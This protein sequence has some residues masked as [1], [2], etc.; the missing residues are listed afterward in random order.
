MKSIIVDTSVI[1]KWYNEEESSEKASIIL[2]AIESQEVELVF[3]QP[4]SLEIL[5]SLKISKGFSRDEIEVALDGFF[6]LRIEW[7]ELDRDLLMETME[8]LLNQNITSYDAL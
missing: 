8:V 1:L 6:Q 4:A 2:R 3:P 7:V 5:N